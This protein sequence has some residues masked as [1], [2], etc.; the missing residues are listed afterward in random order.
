MSVWFSYER[1]IESENAIVAVKR[2]RTFHSRARTRFTW[3]PRRGSKPDHNGTRVTGFAGHQPHF[4]RLHL[5]NSRDAHPRRTCESSRCSES[6]R[7][8]IQAG[9]VASNADSLHCLRYMSALVCPR[10]NSRFQSDGSIAFSLHLIFVKSY[11][12]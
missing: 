9:Y 7:I 11:E 5:G 8:R 6:V 2:A 10:S 3:I 12:S 1:F 4:V